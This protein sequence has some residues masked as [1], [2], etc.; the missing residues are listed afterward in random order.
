[1]TNSQTISKT[2]TQQEQLVETVSDWR[3]ENLTVDRSERVIRNIA[4]TGLHSRNGY[5]YS[6]QALR[7]A[8]PYYEQKPVFLDHARNV[9]RPYERSTRDLVGSIE[10]ARFEEDRV[11]ADIRVL[12]TEAG[13]TFLALAEANGP[14]VGMSHVILAERTR[15]QAVVEMIHD[16]VSVDAVVFPATTTNLRESQSRTTERPAQSIEA[17]LQKI[18]DRLAEHCAQ[19]TGQEIIDAKRVGLFAEQLLLECC[20]LEDHIVVNKRILV[21]WTWE[22]GALHLGKSLTEY[23]SN[24]ELLSLPEAFSNAEQDRSLLVEQRQELTDRLATFENEQEYADRERDVDQLIFASGLPDFAIDDALR[25]DLLH[26]EDDG[27]RQRLID[28]RKQLIALATRQPPTSLARESL[29]TGLSDAQF[30]QTI[31]RAA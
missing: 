9:T 28:G 1:M 10:N 19:L 21:D 14:F 16:V 12:E 17:L 26:A 31:R 6:E 15:D 13:K 7:N 4:L 27:Q 11:R 29:A 8:L 2:A 3:S 23:D 25:D 20:L 18:D 22:D 5:R 30:V 24:D